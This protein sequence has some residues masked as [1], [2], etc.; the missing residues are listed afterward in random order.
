MSIIQSVTGMSPAGKTAAGAT[1]AGLMLTVVGFITGVW[2]YI[3]YIAIALVVAV[4]LVLGFRMFLTW[5]QKGRSAP[6]I[7]RLL[8]TTSGSPATAD[9]AM[10]AKLD[11]LRK[12]FEEGIEKYKAAG[13]DV[14]AVPWVLMAGPSGSGKTEAI[15][16]CNVGF[17][18]GLQDPLQGTGGTHNMNWW[19]MNPAVVLDTAG[20]LFME[21]GGSEWKELM[22]L[23]KNWRPLQPING[24]ILAIGVDSL[25]K[26]SAEKI[27]IEAAKVARQLDAITRDL[28][29]RFPIYIWVTKCDLLIGF[30]EYFSTISDPQL[31]HQMLGWSNPADL[32]EP[33]QADKVTEHLDQV[34]RRLIRRRGA[35]LSDP[36]PQN[37]QSVNPRRIDEVD[38]MYA[39]PES[40]ASI[41]SRLRRYLELIFVQG[42]WSAK[43]LFLRGIYFTS[44]LQEGAELDE[45]IARAMGVPVDALPGGSTFTNTK[46][47]YFL[48]DVLMSKVFP[49]KGLVTRATNVKQQQRGRKLA[50]LGSGIGVV[51]LCL[52]FTVLGY[53]QLAGRVNGPA[54]FWDRVHRELTAAGGGYAVARETS[55]GKIEVNTAPSVTTDWNSAAQL[56]AMTGDRTKPENA[57]RPPVIFKALAVAIP[58]SLQ[59][60][61]GAAH[62]AVAD[63]SLV[64]PLVQAARHRFLAPEPVDWVGGDSAAIKVLASLVQFERSAPVGKPVGKLS[65]P[66]ADYLRFTTTPDEFK[67]LGDAD[68]RKLDDAVDHAVSSTGAWP[69][70]GMKGSSDPKAIDAAATAFNNHWPARLEADPRVGTLLK[71]QAALSKFDAADKAL[72]ALAKNY[73]TTVPADQKQYDDFKAQWDARYAEL[74]RSWKQIEGNLSAVSLKDIDATVTK[75]GETF[76]K[77][78]DDSYRQVL[79]MS[80]AD[81]MADKLGG[82]VLDK[83]KGADSKSD[84]GKDDSKKIGDLA[85]QA[86]DSL[87]FSGDPKDLQPSLKSMYETWHALKAPGGVVATGLSRLKD[88][89]GAGG[90]GA[91]LLADAAGDPAIKHVVAARYE[92]YRQASEIFSAPTTPVAWGALKTDKVL[93]L[94][95]SI[96]S[97][98]SDL[99]ARQ[100]TIDQRSKMAVETGTDAPAVLKRTAEVGAKIAAMG[101]RTAALDAALA[102]R[103][104]PDPKWIRERVEALAGEISLAPSADPSAPPPAP[105]EIALPAPIFPQA[106]KLE[107]GFDPAAAKRVLDDGAAIVRLVGLGADGK[108]A[109][110]AQQIVDP[111]SRAAAA[112]E[113]TEALKAYSRLYFQD[114]TS[115]PAQA[116]AGVNEKTWVDYKKAVDGSVLSSMGSI[117]SKLESM[118]TLMQQALRSIPAEFD[119]DLNAG[120]GQSRQNWMDALKADADQN[121]AGSRRDA[122]RAW[123]KLSDNPQNALSEIAGLSASDL[124]R[125]YFSDFSGAGGNVRLNTPATRYWDLI[126]LE[127]LSMIVQEIKRAQGDLFESLQAMQVLPLSM[128]PPAA[129]P[130]DSAPVQGMPVERVRSIEQ[131]LVALSGATPGKAAA[132]RGKAISTGDRT[133]IDSIDRLLE[134]LFSGNKIMEDPRAMPLVRAWQSWLPVISDPAEPLRV[135]VYVLPGVATNVTAPAAE[136]EKFT[137]SAGTSSWFGLS[138]GGRS[139]DKLQ[140]RAAAGESGVKLGAEFPVLSP[141][142]KIDFFDYENAGERKSSGSRKLVSGWSILE[143]LT[144]PDTRAWGAE[145]G[146]KRWM[147][148]VRFNGTV[149]GQP[150]RYYMWMGLEFSKPLPP[151]STWPG[152]ALWK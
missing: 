60:R 16:H 4:L 117:S 105:A 18:P 59:D 104:G 39:L 11:D 49:E 63:L 152:T 66:V 9:P 77:T 91:A 7:G 92:V 136:L 21:E 36:T 55:P 108:S 8:G 54:S 68:I 103:Q 87:R 146:G 34:C 42:E 35:L 85:E 31:Q 78:I 139:P 64:R 62:S 53:F 140:N 130:A 120:P 25:I 1:G 30:R 99:A 57:I 76:I 17:P 37:M 44:A 138:V 38:A 51:V 22:K 131:N 115:K 96:D 5:R 58:E 133:R 23:L 147:V 134:R 102:G 112:L 83:A 150:G 14:Y 27:E 110:A 79:G 20:R 137:N 145:S 86:A 28:D 111:K 6:F 119:A 45:A 47:S 97:I 46:K 61:V 88:F 10:R 75:A 101:R 95:D 109:G 80:A 107:R 74:T 124:V 94:R 148:P 135:T 122:L 126:R 67:K 19:F 2:I 100:T 65:F 32:D 50:L 151:Q 15:R 40:L 118:G 3:A 82:A 84:A 72:I 12:R 69:P 116:M 90:R 89:Y 81:S 52:A 123:L 132:T 143:L 73:E 144:D 125:D 106:Y 129:W 141:D 24:M 93:S 142:V 13:K 128:E 29:V 71:L 56:L 33:F 70:A 98:D 149:N 41:G 26:D 113:A 127:C 43:P 121:V 114:W 48:R